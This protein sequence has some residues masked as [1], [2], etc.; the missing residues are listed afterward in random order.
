LPRLRESRALW[1]RRHALRRALWRSPEMRAAARIHGCDCWPI[2][3]EELAGIALLQWPWSARAMDEAAAALDTLTP[4]V[5]LTYAEAGGWGRALILECRRRNI[6]TVGLQHGFI[7]RHWLNYLHEPDEMIPDPGNAG[8]RGFPLPSLTL[9]FDQYAA[10]HLAQAG[11][12]PPGSIRVSGSPRLDDLVT[13]ASRLTDADVAN[14]RSAAGAAPGDALLLVVTKHREA[15]RLLPAL[16][17]AAAELRDV[18]LAI[19]THPAET[20]SVYDEI[21]RSQRHV[22]GL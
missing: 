20:P 4:R 19:K 15:R 11:R 1:R 2:V 8:D 7:Y 10:T 3:R 13:T 16:A 17:A 5:A 6:P 9:A 22:S 14:A 12:F 18:H 21:A